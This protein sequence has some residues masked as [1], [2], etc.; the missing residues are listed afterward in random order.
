[1]GQSAGNLLCSHYPI[2]SLILILIETKGKE[3]KNIRNVT[4]YD[5]RFV[6]ILCFC[7]R[8][9]QILHKPHLPEKFQINFG[10]VKRPINK[11][12]KKNI[13]KVVIFAVF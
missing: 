5:V 7:G 8:L 2:F 11:R 10:S 12:K 6:H 1:M 4:V 13:V 3:K 9:I